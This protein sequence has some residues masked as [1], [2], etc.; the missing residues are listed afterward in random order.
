M[1]LVRGR[2]YSEMDV[3]IVGI[4]ATLKTQKIRSSGSPEHVMLCLKLIMVPLLLCQ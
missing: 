3:T 1:A 2:D 4:V